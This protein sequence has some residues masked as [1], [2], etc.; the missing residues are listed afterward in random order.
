[1]ITEILEKY[2]FIQETFSSEIALSM[3]IWYLY[4]REK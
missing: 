3:Y 4:Q 1:M 2:G